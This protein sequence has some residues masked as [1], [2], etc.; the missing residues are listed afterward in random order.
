METAG[1]SAGKGLCGSS[2]M[3]LKYEVNEKEL[4]ACYI[5]EAEFNSLI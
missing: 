2:R 1:W 3:K 5:E 4:I